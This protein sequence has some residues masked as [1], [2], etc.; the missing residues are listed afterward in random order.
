M[1]RHIECEEEARNPMQK[2]VE[3]KEGMTIL[4]VVQRGPPPLLPCGE[5]HFQNANVYA[6]LLTNRQG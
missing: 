4:Q 3:Q 5:W 1:K 6:T 2:K